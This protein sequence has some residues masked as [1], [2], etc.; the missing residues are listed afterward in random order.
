MS[1]MK[2]LFFIFIVARLL[3]SSAHGQ[4]QLQINVEPLVAHSGTINSIALA[5]DGRFLASGSWDRAIKLWDIQNSA[6]LR[7]LVG[8]TDLVLKIA[9]SPD[10]TLLAS[11]SRDGE[12][13]L[14]NTT[15]GQPLATLLGHK[16]QLFWVSFSQDGQYLFS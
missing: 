9:I 16:K 4:T 8:H 2:R 15:T 13:R 11:G 6:L 7:T 10:N 12:I 1:Q 14:W 3:L 5:S